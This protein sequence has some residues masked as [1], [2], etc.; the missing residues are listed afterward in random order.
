VSQDFLK[1]MRQEKETLLAGKLRA[2]PL[3]EIREAALGTGPP[4]PFTA[5]LSGEP[6]SIIG[7][8]KR[9]SPSAGS[10]RQIP[11]PAGVAAALERGGA[12]AVSVLTEGNF[13]GGS[14]DD[15]A[16]VRR[17]T[18]LPLLRKD[19]L[20]HPH[21]L[22][23]SRLHGA[24]AVLLIAAMLKQE[25]MEE[26]LEEAFRAGL[27]CL[28]EVHGPGEIPPVLKA[29]ATL[30]GVNNRN[31]KSLEVDLGT[32]LE[33]APMIPPGMTLVAESGYRSRTD[34]LTAAGA[35]ADAFL[36]G[37]ALMASDDVEAALRL[38]LE[39]EP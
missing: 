33:L 20:I 13:F 35:G 14:L 34:L 29:G 38:L 28:V 3:E 21:D 15:L 6:F 27:E 12:S 19:F 24:D 16:A 8:V 9:S 18:S 31:L 1:S 26:M 10:I 36:I 17:A 7:E 30:I 2:R 37:G 23:E 32:F 4:R 25:E 39:G 11:D 22:Y 5:S